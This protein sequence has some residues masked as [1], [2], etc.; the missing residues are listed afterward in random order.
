MIVH[1][2]LGIWDHNIPDP[3]EDPKKSTPPSKLQNSYGVDYRTL[4][5]IYFLDQPMGLGYW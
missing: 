1:A 4:R 5:G 3:C 2:A